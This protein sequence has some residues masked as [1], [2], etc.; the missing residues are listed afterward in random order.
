MVS[1]SSSPEGGEPPD[2]SAS[3]LSYTEQFYL[4]LPFYL[5]I[6][7]TYDQYWNEDCCLVKYYRRAYEIQRERRNYE[8]WLQ[9]MYI[10]DAL[11]DASPLM[12]AF[13]K[14]GTK[15]V[16]YPTEPYAITSQAIARRRQEK[17]KAKYEKIKAK[18]NAYMI[19]FNARMAKR[20][21]ADK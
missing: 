18:T 19:D 13:S 1:G 6:G 17:E 15:P 9:G 8:M 21:E 3:F 7:M 4:H 2:G 16:P 20:K 14:K 12:R 5:S 11:C 10:Y